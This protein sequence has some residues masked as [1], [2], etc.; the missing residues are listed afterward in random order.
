MLK[1]M[2]CKKNGGFTFFIPGANMYPVMMSIQ[3]HARG[4]GFFFIKTVQYGAFLVFQK[5]L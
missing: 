1:L 3:I 2:K 5:T 4:L